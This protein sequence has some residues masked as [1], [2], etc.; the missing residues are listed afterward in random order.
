MTGLMRPHTKPEG[1]LLQ[2]LRSAFGPTTGTARTLEERLQSLTEQQLQTVMRTAH[3][4][5]MAST[6][7][8]SPT[9]TYQQ[10]VNRMYPRMGVY[11]RSLIAEVL[12]DADPI[13]VDANTDDTSSDID[14]K[15]AVLQE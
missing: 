15:V 6:F 4:V 12:Q 13:F 10:L 5:K 14:V 3:M 11:L 1:E 9:E 8:Y 7:K 2:S